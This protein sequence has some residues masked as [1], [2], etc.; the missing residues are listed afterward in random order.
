MEQKNNK[1][2]KNDLNTLNNKLLP[3]M[4]VIKENIFNENVKQWINALAK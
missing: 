4:K 2:N 1:E 3:D